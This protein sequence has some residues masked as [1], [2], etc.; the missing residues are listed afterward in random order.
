M[1]CGYSMIVRTK[2]CVALR[3]GAIKDEPV[4]FGQ[5]FQYHL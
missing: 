2:W 5:L 4:V 1:L 3:V